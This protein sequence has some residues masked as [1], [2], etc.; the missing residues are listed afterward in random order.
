MY[1]IR[2]YKNLDIKSKIISYI[3]YVTTLWLFLYIY[4]LTIYFLIHNFLNSSIRFS[5]FNLDLVY[6]RFDTYHVIVNNRNFKVT[7]YI[8]VTIFVTL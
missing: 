2:R 5:I 3:T 4:I 1:I 7:W 6:D 8:F